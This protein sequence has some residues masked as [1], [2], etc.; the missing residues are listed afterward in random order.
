M[1]GYLSQK[2]DEMQARC[3]QIIMSRVEELGVERQRLDF[4]TTKM[5][6]ISGLVGKKKVFCQL[7]P[8]KELRGILRITQ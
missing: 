3:L 4:L 8:H 5:E 1:E 2:L 7:K 6:E